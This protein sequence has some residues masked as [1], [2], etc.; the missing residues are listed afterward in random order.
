MA[1]LLTDEGFFRPG[2]Q[3]E[4]VDVLVNDPNDDWT[5]D[6]TDDGSLTQLSPTKAAA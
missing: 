3:L 2:K 1:D 6:D 5:L 4:N